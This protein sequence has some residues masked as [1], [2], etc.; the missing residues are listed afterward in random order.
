VASD[1][2]FLDGNDTVLLTKILFLKRVSLFNGHALYFLNSV[3]CTFM[4]YSRTSNNG[5]C[6]GIQILSVI[7]V[8]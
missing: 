2:N 7:G 1:G 4:Y 5:H 8:R 6:Q 3:N